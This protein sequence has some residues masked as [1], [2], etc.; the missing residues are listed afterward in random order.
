MGGRW[1]QLELCGARLLVD[2]ALGDLAEREDEPRVD[3]VAEHLG[4]ADVER[5]ERGDDAEHASGLV[6]RGSVRNREL[7][8]EK[9]SKEA[10][11]ERAR[12]E[13]KS[14][15]RNA[16]RDRRNDVPAPRSAK[17]MVRKKKRMTRPRFFRRQPMR[18]RK[19]M[20]NHVQR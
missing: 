12:I 9:K 6:E 10:A 2:A 16:I 14:S 20:M 7:A 17:V 11:E 1:R 15:A 19:V 18:R 3:A 13:S 5:D 8:C 4:E